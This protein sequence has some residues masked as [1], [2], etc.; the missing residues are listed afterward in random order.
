MTSCEQLFWQYGV[1]KTH[2]EYLRHK[3]NREQFINHLSTGKFNGG[4]LILGFDCIMVLVSR[5]INKSGKIHKL[6]TILMPFNSSYKLCMFTAGHCGRFIGKGTAF[7][8]L[9]T[10][11]DHLWCNSLYIFPRLQAADR[12][13]GSAGHPVICAV[14]LF[15]FLVRFGRR[16]LSLAVRDSWLRK[17]VEIFQTTK[18][19]LEM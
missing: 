5:F 17:L 11:K 4:V 16:H 12:Y 1:K 2:V 7:H 19:T 13:I 18:S 9:N 3:K 10:E 8:R 14:L 15:F 6:R